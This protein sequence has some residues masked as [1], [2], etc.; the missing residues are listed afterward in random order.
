MLNINNLQYTLIKRDIGLIDHKD[1]SEFNFKGIVDLVNVNDFM[2]RISKL[3]K[4]YITYS[5][6]QRKKYMDEILNFKKNNVSEKKII[7]LIK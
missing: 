7:D 4:N 6:L 5:D 2:S 1:N 3:N